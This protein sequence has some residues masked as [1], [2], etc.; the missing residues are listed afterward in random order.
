[1]L[2][3]V[4]IVVLSIP[5]VLEDASPVLLFTPPEESVQLLQV[6]KSF[7]ALVSPVHT[8]PA[9]IALVTGKAN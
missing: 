4:G 6:L 3:Q 9:P 5:V 1:M 8:L 7:Q 2:L